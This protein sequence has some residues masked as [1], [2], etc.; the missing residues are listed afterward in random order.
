[1]TVV[2]YGFSMVFAKT[3]TWQERFR[4]LKQGN[5]EVEFKF[6]LLGLMVGSVVLLLGF[7]WWRNKVKSEQQADSHAGEF[8]RLATVL[9]LSKP[10]RT[11][12]VRIARTNQLPTPITLLLSPGTL[13]HCAQAH[14]R[15]LSAVKSAVVKQQIKRIG[16]AAFD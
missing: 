1:M 12:L 16:D 14:A 11:L 4:A 5:E 7:M 3:L 2:I 15:S 8:R 9:N 10:D 13:I 6:W